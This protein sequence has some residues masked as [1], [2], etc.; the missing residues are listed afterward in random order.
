MLKTGSTSRDK[1]ARSNA[2]ANPSM[3]SAM[4]TI[5]KA[6]LKVP[7]PNAGSKKRS[8]GAS[9]S[10]LLKSKEVKLKNSKPTPEL[11]E[12]GSEETDLSTSEGYDSSWISWFCGLR[13]NELLCE[14]DEDYIQDD[15]NLCGLQGLVPY[16]DYALDMILDNDS[17]S[18]FP[19]LKDIC[20]GDID[21]EEHSQVESAAEQL[22]GLIHARYIVTSRGLNAMHE[23][24]KKADF[25]C[26]PRVFCGGQPCLPVGT[27]DI[28]HNG[29][30]KIY[31]P[32]CEDVYFPR[33]KYQSNMDGAYIGTTFPHLYL[34]TY[35]TSKPP[36]EVQHYVPKVFGFKL[37]KGTKQLFDTS[38]NTL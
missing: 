22:Y 28:P 32:K 14:I 6:S 34:M 36:A 35:P 37:H 2:N 9:T 8:D 12:I 16:Y 17:L 38:T 7:L 19:P 18:A 23:K 24:Y 10:V 20:S 31:C 21:G 4:E 33:C 26:C 25:G 15:F 1:A 11:A 3:G 13:G 29:S 27:S 5:S 30:V